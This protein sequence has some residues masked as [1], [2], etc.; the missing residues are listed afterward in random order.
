M[1]TSDADIREILHKDLNSK[2]NSDDALILDELVVC[3]GKARV[4]VA[5]INGSFT[6]YEIKSEKDTLDRLPNQIEAYNKVFDNMSIITGNNHTEEVKSMVPEWW[7]IFTASYDD[8]NCVNIK[9]V[10]PPKGGPGKIHWIPGNQDKIPSLGQFDASNFEG[11][12]NSIDKLLEIVSV[13]SKTPKNE[14]SRGGSG[15]VPT[16]VALRT[17]YQPFIG[18]TNE[19]ANLIK[20]AGESLIRKILKMTEIDDVG[21]D[22]DYFD[23]IP[24]V[25]IEAGLPEDEQEKAKV[26]EFEINNKIKSRRTIQQERGVEDIDKEN[27]QIESETEDIYGDRLLQGIE[28]LGGEEVEL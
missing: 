5:V 12:L 15:S 7:G 6:G 21:I 9:S 16:G 25:H 14:L 27:E 23:Y 13:I 8:T 11:L 24:E 19:K 3:H 4:D 28:G 18:K 17:I 22:F 26:H 1:K 20:S 2:Y 10:R